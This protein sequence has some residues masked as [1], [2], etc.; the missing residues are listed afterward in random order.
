VGF[1][2]P[3]SRPESP[4]T[5][6]GSGRDRRNIRTG[7]RERISHTLGVALQGIRDGAQRSGLQGRTGHRNG[8]LR[9]A[10]TAGFDGERTL[11]GSDLGDRWFFLFGFEKN[12]RVN[13]DAREL[14]SLQSIAH[15]L[16]EM[17]SRQLDQAVEAGELMEIET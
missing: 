5:H 11:I 1:A 9:G 16:L 13:I 8:G 6:G 14:A 15:V 17:K 10:G 4:R 3:A 7:R 2:S 12:D